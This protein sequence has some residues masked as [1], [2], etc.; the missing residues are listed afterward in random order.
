MDKPLYQQIASD[1][2]E[3][4]SSGILALD[5]QVPTEKEL[6]DTYK[7]SRITSK[8]ALSE[9]EQAGLIYRVQGKGSFVKNTDSYSKSTKR[10]LFLLPFNNDLSLGNFNEGLMPVMQEKNIDVL[11]TNVDFLDNKNAEEIIDEFDGLIYYAISQENRIEL[12][13]DLY[14]KNFPLIILDK[15]IH[16]IDLPTILSDNRG[17]GKLATDK[18]VAGGHRKI[19][20]IFGELH[21]PQSTRERYLGYLMSIKENNL[22][23]QTYLNDER[24]TLE[25]LV[26]YVKEHGLSAIVCENDL[27]AIHAM[28]L[29]KDN[30]YQIPSDISVIG[31]DNIQAASLVEP[32]LT[33]ISQDFKEIGRLAGESLLTWIEDGIKPSSSTIP[34]TF[35]Q[36]D[37]SI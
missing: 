17:G 3:Q 33:T 36:R 14:L 27:T 5:S 28:K 15:K 20:Y 37:S 35:I 26:E 2:K 21:P 16:E 32:A 22:S 10:I 7:V 34:V 23:F 12:L 9:L 13:F 8:R 4:I 19:G 1:L 18:L 30:G 24:A 29:L 6:S 11:A 25:T 31:F